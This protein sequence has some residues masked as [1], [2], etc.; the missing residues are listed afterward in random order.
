MWEEGGVMTRCTE[1]NKYV[2][3]DNLRSG[4]TSKNKGTSKP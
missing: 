2:N 1:V 3:Y 4:S